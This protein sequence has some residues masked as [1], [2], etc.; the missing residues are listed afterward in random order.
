MSFGL[1]DL[2]A[3]DAVG[4]RLG[5]GLHP[6]LRRRIADIPPGTAPHGR[7]VRQ[8]R[9]LQAVSCAR[10]A[11]DPGLV[12]FPGPATDATSRERRA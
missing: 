5:C 3:A 6:G 10:I 11:G 9:P 2:A 4:R 8:S 7:P 1:S 12:A